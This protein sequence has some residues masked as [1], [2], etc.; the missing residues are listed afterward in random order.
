MPRRSRRDSIT[1][2]PFRAPTTKYQSLAL[3]IAVSAD[4][5]FLNQFFT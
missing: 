2:N 3:R 1:Q 5:R 4:F